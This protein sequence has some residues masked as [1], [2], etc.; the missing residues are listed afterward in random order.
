MAGFMAGVNPHARIALFL[1]ALEVT[2]Q[3]GQLLEDAYKIALLSL[4]L[5]HT[6]TIWLGFFKPALQ[7]F[8]AGRADAVEVKAGECEQGIPYG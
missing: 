6:H 2:V 8:A 7:P 1:R 4:D 5:L 3:T